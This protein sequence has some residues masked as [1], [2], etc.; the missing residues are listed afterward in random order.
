[1]Q[2]IILYLCGMNCTVYAKAYDSSIMYKQLYTYVFK[3]FT[4]M[5]Y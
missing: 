5:Y 1:M 3:E 4:Y 2:I